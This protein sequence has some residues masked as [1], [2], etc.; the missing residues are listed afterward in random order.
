MLTEQKTRVIGER[1]S[2][3]G[4]AQ[5]LARGQ[6]SDILPEKMFRTCSKSE[7]Q[8]SFHGLGLSG[9]DTKLAD[10]ISLTVLDVQLATL[11]RLSISTKPSLL[12]RFRITCRSAAQ[13]SNDHVAST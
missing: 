13:S 5:C 6:G 4:A 12:E 11:Y 10:L 9:F 8:L 3:V 7:N 2:K 1:G